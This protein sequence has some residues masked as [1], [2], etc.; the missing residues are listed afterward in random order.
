MDFT[1][2]LI[3]FAIVN[4]TMDWTINNGIESEDEEVKMEV[5]RLDGGEELVKAVIRSDGYE[6]REHIKEICEANRGVFEVTNDGEIKCSIDLT[7]DDES[8]SNFSEKMRFLLLG[9]EQFQYVI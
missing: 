8:G 4:P 9:I 5:E 6:D 2:L 3:I 1:L 7:T